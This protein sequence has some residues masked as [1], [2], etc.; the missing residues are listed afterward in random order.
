MGFLDGG[1][2]R[3]AAEHLAETVAREAL[4]G[5]DVMEFNPRHPDAPGAYRLAADLIKTLAFG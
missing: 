2:C 1:G 4:P 5:L 3:A